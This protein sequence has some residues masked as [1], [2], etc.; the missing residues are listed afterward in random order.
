MKRSMPSFAAAIFG[1][2]LC[3]WAVTLRSEMG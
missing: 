3:R 1:V 2:D